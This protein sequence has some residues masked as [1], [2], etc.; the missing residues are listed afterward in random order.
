[1]TAWAADRSYCVRPGET[2]EQCFYRLIARCR[3]ERA[4]MEALWICGPWDDGNPW[5]EQGL[6]IL[7]QALDV[8]F[9][10]RDL[11]YPSEPPST[12]TIEFVD[13]NGPNVR[14]VPTEQG[15]ILDPHTER[16]AL[17][18]VRTERFHLIRISLRN[19]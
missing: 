9:F 8:G 13:P 4:H 2:P 14:L 10:L 19:R 11:L 6:G 5:H 1:M 16:P 18:P 15:R 7:R 12:A 17:P 3:V